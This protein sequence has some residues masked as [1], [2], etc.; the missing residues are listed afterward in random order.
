MLRGL[1]KKEI[2]EQRSDPNSIL[3]RIW[4]KRLI[5]KQ[6]IKSRKTEKLLAGHSSLSTQR[7]RESL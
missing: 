4:F 7:N 3:N 6:V 5:N 2:V 1:S